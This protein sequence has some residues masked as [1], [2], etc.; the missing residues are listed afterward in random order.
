[1]QFGEIDK[2]V[3]MGGSRRL[4]NLVETV[5]GFKIMVLSSERLMNESVDDCG[6]TLKKWLEQSNVV[7]Y[8]VNNI[9]NF[10]IEKH[11][12]GSTLGVSLGAPWIL[13]KRLLSIFNGKIIN[14]HSAKLPQNRGG[15]DFSWQIMRGLNFGYH[16][17]HVIDE[18]V[19]TGPI[20]YSTEFIFPHTCRTSKELKMYSMELE[21]F[22]LGIF[23]EK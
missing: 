22:F 20:V 4:V 7:H 1:M 17:F 12:D 19:D 16:L 23:L 15:G 13:D 5:T 11:V 8:C 18:G 21:K 9:D 10:E 6:V 3:L 2:I 14:G